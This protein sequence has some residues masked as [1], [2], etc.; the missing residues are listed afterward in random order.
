MDHIMSFC[1][2]CGVLLPE[3]L[4]LKDVPRCPT[5][6]NYTKMR[7]ARFEG[8]FSELDATAFQLLMY[9]EQS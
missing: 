4:G 1:A 9:G 8:T 2:E 7:A 3:G 5:C 6:G